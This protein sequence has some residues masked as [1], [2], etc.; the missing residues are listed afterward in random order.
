MNG[1]LLW[2]QQQEMEKQFTHIRGY[3]YSN[4]LRILQ[5]EGKALHMGSRGEYGWDGWLGCYFSNDPQNRISIVFMTQCKDAGT[6]PVL[7]KMKNAL[8]GNCL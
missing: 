6:L 7:R 2:N 8:Y 3:A 1:G 5:E 4:L